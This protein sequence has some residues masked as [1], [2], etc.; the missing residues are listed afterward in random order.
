MI[1]K[2]ELRFV[3]FTWPNLCSLDS[4]LLFIVS[5]GCNLSLFESDHK[6]HRKYNENKMNKKEK[7]K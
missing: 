2:Y 5:V 3:A 1:F 4:S 6:I 7:R